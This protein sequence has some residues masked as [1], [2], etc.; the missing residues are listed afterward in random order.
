MYYFL[1]EDGVI[2][3]SGAEKHGAY[4]NVEAKG[5]DKSAQRRR[6]R[7]YRRKDEKWT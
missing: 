4:K 1:D 7:K 3:G 2:I 5:A 6:E